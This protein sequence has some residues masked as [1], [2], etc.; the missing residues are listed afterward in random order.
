MAKY[1]D[2]SLGMLVEQDKEVKEFSEKPVQ[3]VPEGSSRYKKD[4]DELIE[5]LEVSEDA[6]E[7]N[8]AYE[9]SIKKQ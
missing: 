6:Y 2:I 4:N 1:L 5:E 9:A 3:V 7:Q 8:V